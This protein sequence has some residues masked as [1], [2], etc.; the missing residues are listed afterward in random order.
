[1]EDRP[2]VFAVTVRSEIGKSRCTLFAIARH[3][4]TNFGW[5]KSVL[6]RPSNALLERHVR[7][8]QLGRVL[9]IKDSTILPY[10]Y[11]VA[12]IDALM[13]GQIRKMVT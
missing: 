5:L 6:A 12:S 8:Y 11:N 2:V 9:T 13:K 7:S 10:H 3:S 4:G 1:M